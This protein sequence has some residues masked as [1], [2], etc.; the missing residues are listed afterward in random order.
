MKGTKK[1][2]LEPRMNSNTRIGDQSVC[3]KDVRTTKYTKNTKISVADNERQKKDMLG[4]TD[5]L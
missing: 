2:R 3:G 4:T 1:T 5:E